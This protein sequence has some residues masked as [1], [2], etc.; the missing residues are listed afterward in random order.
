MHTAKA[1]FLL[2]NSLLHL[3]IPPPCLFSFVLASFSQS[4]FITCHFCNTSGH[5][6]PYAICIT[7]FMSS[8]LIKNPL[9]ERLCYLLFKFSSLHTW[10]F[11]VLTLVKANPK[12]KIR[13]YKLMLRY[14]T[15]SRYHSQTN[16]TC[17]SSLLARMKLIWL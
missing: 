11:D 9:L 14:H 13:Y 8:A 7:S 12:A 16:Q 3:L 15:L 17:L 2:L 6:H 4:E 5:L 1:L 10:H